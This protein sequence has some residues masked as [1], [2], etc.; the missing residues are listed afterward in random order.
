MSEHNVNLLWKEF[1]GIRKLHSINSDKVLGADIAHNIRLSKEKSGEARSIRS[2]GW[3]SEWTE[4]TEN[5]IRLFS[6]NCS[7]YSA[8]DQLVA[9]TK[10]NSAINAWLI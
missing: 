4:M 7:G 8:P 2:S 5:V 3:F 6:A 1:K 9:F 10:T